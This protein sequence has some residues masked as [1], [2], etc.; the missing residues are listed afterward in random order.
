M[1]GG[2]GHKLIMQ[3]DGNLVVYNGAGAAAWNCFASR[4]NI[5]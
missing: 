3:N 5:L 4:G 1:A 2:S